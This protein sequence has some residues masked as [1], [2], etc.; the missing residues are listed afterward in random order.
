MCKK[1]SN[2]PKKVQM[3]QMI[4]QMSNKHSSNE[5]I[6]SIEQKYSSYE[7]NC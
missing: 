3:S 7:Q 5:Q 4:A 2:E 1:C 6:N